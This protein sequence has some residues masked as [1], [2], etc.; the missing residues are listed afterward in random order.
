M[1]SKT[2]FRNQRR[3]MFYWQDKKPYVSVTNVLKVIDKPA[4]RY[5]FG[6]QV[7]L[8]MTVDPTMNEK[9]ALA[10]PYKKSKKAMNRGTTVHSIV[11]AYKKTGAVIDSVP[12]DYQGYAKAF[13]KW[14]DDNKIEVVENEKT[15]VSESMGYAGTLDM[16]V[17]KNG[18]ET[19]IIDV[20][21]GKDIYAEAH[22]QLSAYKHA[23]KEDFGQKID[24]MG[25]LLL[26]ENGNYKFEE[27]DDNIDVF[28]A[29]QQIWYFLNKEDCDKVGY[30]KRGGDVNGQR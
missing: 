29:C 15:V 24:R 27:A 25:V 14:I 30:V 12:E 28:L 7:Y 20:K 21:T 4:L 18:T 26:K 13:Y 6:K 19:W 9:E 22:I 8:A 10:A 2:D 3:G 16:M 23:L 1:T 17:K 5:W 11:E